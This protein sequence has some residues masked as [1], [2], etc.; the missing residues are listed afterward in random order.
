MRRL[1]A[2]LCMVTVNWLA[3]PAHA[4]EDA[5]DR[6]FVA[7]PYIEFHTGPGRGYPVFFV[8]QRG[9]NIEILMRRTDWFMVRSADGKVGWASRA[10]LETTLTEAGTKKT[11]RDVLVDDY[12]RRKVEVGVAWG[13]FKS[14]PMLKAWMGYRLSDT[15]SAEVNIG[16]VQGVFSSTDFWHIGLNVEPWSDKRFSPYFGIGFG[17]FKNLPNPSLVSNTLTNVKMGHATTGLRY[18]VSDRFL[19][20]VDYSIYTAYLSSLRIGEYRA[21]TVGLSFFF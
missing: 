13:R 11:F 15:L 19:A 12:L 18:Y 7:D 3:L 10:Q 2:A 9:D 17:Q 8:V 6:V 14:D 20:R 5:V 4:A 21:A 16:Q 1:I